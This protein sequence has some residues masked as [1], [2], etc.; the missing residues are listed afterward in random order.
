M[1][2]RS[3]RFG[4]GRPWVREGSASARFGRVRGGLELKPWVDAV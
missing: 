2:A 3:R 4:S 1:G